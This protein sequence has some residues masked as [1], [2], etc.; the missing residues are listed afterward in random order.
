LWVLLL[1]IY[2]LLHCHPFQESFTNS[3]VSCSAR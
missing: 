3:R 2:D 1:T